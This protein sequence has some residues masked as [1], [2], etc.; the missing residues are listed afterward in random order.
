MSIQKISLSQEKSPNKPLT[1][2]GGAI[3]QE[4]FLI[5]LKDLLEQYIMKFLLMK[6]V[7]LVKAIKNHLII[8]ESVKLKGN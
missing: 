8:G 7:A 3:F 1:L 4:I 2:V 5:L 6:V